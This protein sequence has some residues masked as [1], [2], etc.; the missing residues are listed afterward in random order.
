MTTAS[1]IKLATRMTFASM[2]LV[3]ASTAC[4]MFMVAW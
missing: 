4:L 3:L 2:C 1:K